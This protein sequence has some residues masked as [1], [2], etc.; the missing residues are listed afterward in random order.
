MKNHNAENAKAIT[1][2]SKDLSQLYISIFQKIRFVIVLSTA[3]SKT[4]P[5]VH[6]TA[7][8]GR[9]YLL[10]THMAEY[11]YCYLYKEI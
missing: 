6:I 10:L 1:S 5:H 7:R 4:I 2:V 11:L 9:I 3:G 8:L